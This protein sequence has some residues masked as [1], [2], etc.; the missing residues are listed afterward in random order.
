MPGNLL[1]LDKSTNA[2]I[3]DACYEEK[4]PVYGSE[5]GN[6]LSASLVT[7]SY[8][9]NPQLRYFLEKTGFDI[10]PYEKFGHE[11]IVERTALL[12]SIVGSLWAP[13]FE[14]IAHEGING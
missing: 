13:D 5:K 10:K 1:L 7:R 9:N 14:E 12:G 8:N 11:Q 3:N 6:I 4:L 2:S